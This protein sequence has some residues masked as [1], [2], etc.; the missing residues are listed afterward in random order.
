LFCR[1]VYAASAVKQPLINVEKTPK[2]LHELFVQTGI[3]AGIDRAA[4]VSRRMA[5]GEIRFPKGVFRFKTVEE[6]SEWK[7]KF[8]AGSQPQTNQAV[9]PKA[10]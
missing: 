3:Q 6:F 8:L 5:S 4:E 9:S 1:A 10:P 2:S 7:E